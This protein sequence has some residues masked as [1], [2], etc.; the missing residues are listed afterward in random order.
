MMEQE[1]PRTRLEQLLRQ[2]HLTLE[3]FRKQYQRAAGG[4][5]LSERQ[6]YRWVAGEVRSPPY[7][8][9]QATLEKMF[10][11]P[12]VRLFGL[13]YGT[14]ALRLTRRHNGMVT[15]RGTDRT[16][17]EGQLIAMS[18]DRARDFLT[19]IEA[20]NV[21][22]ETL[23]Q[24]LDDVRRLVTASQ[25]QSL[26]TWLSDLVD[27][28]NRAFELLE[29]RQRPEQ[30]RDLYLVAG[31]SCGLWRWHQWSWVPSMMRMTQARAGYACADNAGHDGLRAWIRGLQAGHTYWASRWEDS[32]RY[33]QLGAEAAARGR[34]TASVWL[35]SAEARALAALNRLEEAHTALARAAEARDRVQ[36]DE[37]DSLGGICTFSRPRQL[38]FAAD[39]LSWGGQAEAT[40]AERL[41]LETL[42]AY[43]AAPAQDRSFGHEAGTRSALAVACVFQGEIDGAAEALAPVLDLP[44]AQRGHG[45]VISVERVRTA[46]ST[47][48]GPGRDAIALAGAI[49]AFTVERLTQPR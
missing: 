7:P 6:A 34:G 30:T 44:S 33:A 32:V 41:A 42:D 19:R 26:P 13:P 48:N 16:D 39:T 28:Q 25:Q 45:I 29:G 4:T 36:L 2:R 47:I 3:E 9:A 11:E 23:D 38:Y 24:L 37:L 1:S 15:A 10:G 31:I 22:A 27:T 5:V 49:E 40:R 17:W 12:A 46:L 14:G 18:A 43:A 21:G 8:Q 20:S 35:A